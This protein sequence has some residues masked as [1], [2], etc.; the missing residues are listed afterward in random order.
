[1][2]A[3]LG[4]VCAAFAGGLVDGG[5]MEVDASAAS[6][7]ADANAAL[8]AGRFDDAA[9]MLGALADSGGGVPARVAQAVALYEGGDLRGARVAAEAAIKLDA[10]NIACLNVLGLTMVDGGSVEHGLAT[11]TTAQKVAA[12]DP[13]WT[14]RILV[15]IG[16]AKLDRGDRAGALSAFTAAKT[17]GDAATLSAIAAGEVA[18]AGL[19]GNDSGVGQALGSGRTGA[20][21]AEAE[22][23]ASA[24]T[25]RR[26]RVGAGLL[27]AGVERA[28]GRLDAAQKRLTGLIVEAREAGMTREWA[29]ALG[30]LG[31]VQSLAGRLPLAA[32]TLLAG[33]RAAESGG[34]RVVEV[35]LRCELGRVLLHLGRKD[36]AVEQQHA[37]GKLLAAMEYAQ[38]AARQAELGGEIAAASG[39]LSMAE[40]ALSAAATRYGG[41]GRNLDAARAATA[42]A[43]AFEGRDAAKAAG[44]GAAAAG[45]FSKAGDALGPAHVLLARG[46]ANARAKR[47][48]E[49]LAQFA[50]AVELAEKVG[51]GRG[52]AIVAVARE[53]A[54]QT[55]VALG[56]TDEVAKLAS[57]QGMG[58]IIARHQQTQKA[59]DAYDAGLALYTKGD[60]KAARE[61]FVLAR[62]TFDAAGE[63]AYAGRARRSAA[64][65]AYNV[66]VALPTAQ[67][68]PQWQQ[69]VEETA[70]V[71]DAEL[72]ARAYS[73]AVLAA[74]AGGQKELGARY[75]ECVR[76]AAI[77]QLPD[78]GAR[79]WGAM[80]EEGEDL[81][82]RAKSARAAHALDAGEK[83]SVYA[84]YV[85]AVDA[86]NAGRNELAVELA[87]LARPNA[88]RLAGALDEVLAAT[89]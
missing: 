3:A 58:E 64:W 31:I 87:T 43:A 21:R 46:L 56:S 66:L 23:I 30:D 80:A 26:G 52:A 85:V 10:R 44:W 19:S 63:T 35:D 22:R 67:A 79:C 40:A 8:A 57:Q 69:L 86:Y 61:Q 6:V 7:I 45:Y 50:K 81:D 89:R 88:G 60:F 36:E 54:A 20:A 49:A 71:E 78:V 1:M 83:A 39:D 38:G 29:V 41:Q 15:N 18:A 13:R 11:L 76:L 16:L 34:Y 55:L 73:A 5:E 82:D 62:Q 77:A 4:L 47:L 24:A 14:A 74:H 72:F 25:T 68:A 48:P 33:A 37:A 27:L 2:L 51:G 12:G 28:E 32:D 65:S 75:K 17:G 53:D 84:L 70:K 9:G 59:A 42:L